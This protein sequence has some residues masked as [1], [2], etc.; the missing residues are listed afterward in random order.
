[1]TL[2]ILALFSCQ[3]AE[4]HGHAHNEDGGHDLENGAPSVDATVWTDKIE[5]FVEFPALVVGNT[6]RFA[7]HFTILNGHQPVKE[8]AVTV[9]LIKGG[10]GIRQTAEKPSSPGLFTPS[11]QPKEAGIYQLVFDLKTP[12]LTDR[13]VMNDVRVFASAE[14]ARSIHASDNENGAITFLKDQAWSMDFQ[15]APAVEKEI[16]EVIPTSGIWKVAP[17]DYRILVATANGTVA[18]KEQA[19]IEG[20][21]VKKGQV[22]MTI[23]SDGLTSNNLSAE[24]LKAKA[25]LNQAQSEYDRKKELYESEIVPKAEFEEVKQRYEV[26]KA[27]YETLSSGYTA[28]GKSIVVPFEGYVKAISIGNGDFVEQGTPLLTITSHQSSLLEILVSAAYANQLQS[29]HNVYYQPRPGG[30]SNLNET[31]GIIVSIGR[32]VGPDQPMLAVFAKVND[33]IEMPEGSFTEVQLAVGDPVKAV[34]V[35]A[36]ALLED[37]GN[38][39]VIVQLSGERFEKRPV[40]TGKS[41]GSEVEIKEGLKAGEVVVTKGTYQV[42]MTSMSGQAP[43]HGHA[44]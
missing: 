39:S 7:A 12:V 9:S 36:T 22:L 6:S 18:F 10:K 42:K 32:E 37:Y 2:M 35:P 3:K 8:G 23:S 44:H 11:L 5:L 40:V 15:T 24:I 27:N 20:S 14:E 25:G 30:W 17:S 21:K 13:I 1:M 41:N 38:Y 26:A 43:G 34:V 29:L 28:S 31:G 4:E 19:L 16:Y 33:V